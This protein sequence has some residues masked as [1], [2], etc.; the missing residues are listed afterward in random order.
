MKSVGDNSSLISSCILPCI[1]NDKRE[2]TPSAANSKLGSRSAISRPDSSEMILMTCATIFSVDGE[3]IG[4]ATD[5]EPVAAWATGCDFDCVGER[6]FSTA[7]FEDFV[8]EL[9]CEGS[10]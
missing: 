10:R 4:F 3:L 7:R 9:E 2:S 6:G 5:L 8:A 1:V